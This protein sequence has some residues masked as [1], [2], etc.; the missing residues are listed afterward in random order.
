MSGAL[1]RRVPTDWEHYEKYPLSAIGAPSTPTPVVFGINWYQDFDRPTQIKVGTIKIWAIGLDSH[2][3]GSV[4]GGHAIAAEPGGRLVDKDSWHKF[5]D[6]GSEG[7]C[8]GF[9]SSRMMS[10]LN[11][12]RYDGIWLWNQAKM[13]DEWPDTNPGDSNGTSVRAGMAVLRNDGHARVRAGKTSPPRLEDGINA[14]RWARSV[15]EVHATLSNPTADKIG[16][17]PL[18]NSWG[19]YYPWRVWVPDATIQRLIDEDGEVALVTDR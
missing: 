15:E 6:Q 17:I 7:A 18:L 10:I 12:Q 13:I 3:L 19:T 14:Y 16:M 1:G 9:A 8:V 4:R 2:R 5:Y 11:R